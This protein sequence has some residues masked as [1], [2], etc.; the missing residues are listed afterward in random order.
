LKEDNT[1]EKNSWTDRTFRIPVDWL[2]SL[3]TL[4]TGLH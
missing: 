1:H 2:L 4:S 3:Y